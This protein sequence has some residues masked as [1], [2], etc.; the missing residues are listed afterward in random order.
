MQIR[1]IVLHNF[2]STNELDLELP[3]TGVLLVTGPNGAGKSTLVEAVSYGLWGELLR[4]APH[5]WREGVEGFVTITTPDVSASRRTTKAGKRSLVWTAPGG[6]PQEF[7][8]N[9]KAAGALGATIG[10]WDVWVRPHVFSSA[11]AAHFS[12][13]TDKERKLL[14]ET[15]LGLDRFDPALETC[16]SELKVASR[17]LAGFE[18]Q[19]R[20]AVVRLEAET[21]ARDAARRTL[22]DTPL[23]PEVP[24]DVAKQIAELDRLMIGARAEIQKLQRDVRDVHRQAG[25][26]DADLR[27]LQ[28][29]IAQLRDKLCPTCSQEIPAALRDRLTKEAAGIKELHDKATA[30]RTATAA[31]LEEEIAG[32]EEEINALSRRRTGLGTDGM[33]ADRLRE[34]RSRLEA[35]V[36]KADKALGGLAERVQGL[37]EARDAK[38]VEV[39]RLTLAEGVLGLKGVRA[40]M[41]G[42]TLAGIEAVANVW[43]A[44][45]YGPGFQV[46]L[47]PYEEKK[48]GGVR[49]S[50]ALQI[51]GSN[52]HGQTF[53]GGAGYGASSGGE[54]RRVD[55]ALLLAIAEVASAASG[56]SGGTL[57]FDEVLDHVDD[58]GVDA[59]CSAIGTL[60]ADR[61]V[62]V[63]SHSPTLI[64]RIPVT[65]HLHLAPPPIA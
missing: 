48:S 11:D 53:G 57:F 61:C 22:D 18:T 39:R 45:L 33:L 40:H 58:E 42:Q 21:K 35:A 2:M 10:T 49:D 38:G 41:L 59:V 36:A 32:I 13:A 8:S 47:S 25:G 62:V 6:T 60:A 37:Q 55:I 14:L 54:R 7:E 16:R 5:P 23:P 28:S 29:R 15:V 63:I 26:S 20:E 24:D 3:E 19:L 4:N 1:R 31:G 27:H 34:Q 51:T 43:L 50:I 52:R 17:D 44:R 9:T 12:L 65:R 46:K 64:E 30:A 56:R